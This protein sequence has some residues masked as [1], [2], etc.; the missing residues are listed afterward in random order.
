MCSEGLQYLVCVSVC[1]CVCSTF[2]RNET[3]K[4][5]CQQVRCYIG[6]ILKLVIFDCFLRQSSNAQGVVMASLYSW[7]LMEKLGHK[8]RGQLNSVYT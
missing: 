3:A 7:R 8:D 2:R 5:L 1:V 4:K 6:F